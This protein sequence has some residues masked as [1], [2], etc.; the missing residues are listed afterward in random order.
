MPVK[1]TDRLLSTDEA[2][3]RCGVKPPTLRSWRHRNEGPRSFLVG[4]KVVYRES[5]LT[6]WITAQEKSTGRG[7]K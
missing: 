4:T 1:E 2:A 7:G 3:E 5:L 6:A